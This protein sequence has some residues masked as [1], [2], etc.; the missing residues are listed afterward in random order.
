MGLN[1]TFE[2]KTKEGKNFTFANNIVHVCHMQANPIN[3]LDSQ[4][5]RFWRLESIGI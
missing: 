2:K 3:E 1:G 4:M 5:K